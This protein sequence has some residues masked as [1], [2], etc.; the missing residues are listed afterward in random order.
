MYVSANEKVVS[1]NLHRYTTGPEQQ[2]LLAAPF[3][4]QV[5][6]NVVLTRAG[7][8]NA[9][10]RLA[11]EI[12]AP[13]ENYDSDAAAAAAWER[14]GIPPVPRDL[15]PVLKCRVEFA[16]YRKGDP[17]ASTPAG[18]IPSAWYLLTP[19]AALA[20]FAAGAPGGARYKLNL[21]HP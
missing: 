14:L 10:Q 11:T 17:T 20:P 5:Q 19:L 4:P 1:L 3:L 7:L 2:R 21:V 16:G 15:P 9:Y 12:G 18:R 13:R 6:E 8:V